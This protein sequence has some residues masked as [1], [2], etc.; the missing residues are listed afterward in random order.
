[1]DGVIGGWFGL[2]VVVVGRENC[3]RSGYL[4]FENRMI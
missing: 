4:L 3:F 2:F 1:M